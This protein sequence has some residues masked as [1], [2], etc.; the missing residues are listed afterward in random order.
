MSENDCDAARKLV[1]DLWCAMDR[2][3]QDEKIAMLEGVLSADISWRGPA[4]IGD[5]VGADGVL[6][7]FWIPLFRSVP[8]VT[9]KCAILM[10]GDFDDCCWVSATGYLSGRF[11][12]DW[13]GIPAT[14]ESVHIRFGEFW[15]VQSGRVH[16][17]IVGLDILDVMRQAGYPMISGYGGAPGL[18][19]EPLRGDGIMLGQ[20]DPGESDASMNLLELLTR[21]LNSFD[22]FDVASVKSTSYKPADYKWFGPSGIGIANS[23]KEFEDF[24]QKPFLRAFPDRKF[25]D[26]DVA[27]GEGGYASCAAWPSMMATHQHEYLGAAATGGPIQLKFMDWFTRDGDKFIENR[28]WFDLIDLLEQCEIDVMHQLQEA[29]E[30]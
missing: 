30:R 2:R 8:G 6:S 17:C 19:P 21:R 4:P 18:V 12:K 27:L 5:L 22:S 23:L 25:G 15:K 16:E 26:Y 28:V 11:E 24:H 3:P 9:R 14:G 10:A 13:L 1:W 7:K 29:V 20:Q